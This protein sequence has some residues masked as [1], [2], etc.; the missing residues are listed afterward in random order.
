MKNLEEKITQLYIRNLDTILRH[1]NKRKGQLK[2]KQCIDEIINSLKH[3]VNVNEKEKY[4]EARKVI[5]NEYARFW[6]RLFY[7][8][9]FFFFFFFFLNYIIIY[10][11]LYLI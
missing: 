10:I 4:Q 11:S 5:L 8:Y 7:Y 2:K 1:F 9:F 6:Y 3:L